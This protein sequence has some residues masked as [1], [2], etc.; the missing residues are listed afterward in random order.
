[1]RHDPA[2]RC[3]QRS[4]CQLFDV[5]PWDPQILAG[6]TLL[7]VLA[8]LAS[9]TIPARRATRVDPMVALRRE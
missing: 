9:A 7:L 8:T 6:A 5:R 1:V 2:D 4:L 3:R